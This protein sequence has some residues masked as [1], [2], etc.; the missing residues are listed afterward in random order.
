M[1]ESMVALNEIEN[2][3]ERMLHG[4]SNEDE[5]ILRI[6]KILLDSG[7]LQWFNKRINKVHKLLIEH[8]VDDVNCI[9]DP[10]ARHITDDRF[11][12]LIAAIA[13]YIN[14]EIAKLV[15]NEEIKKK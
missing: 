3:V 13:N 5:T 12:S 9:K 4:R 10:F 15:F 14:E 1:T 2:A 6:Q 8:S 7:R 11:S